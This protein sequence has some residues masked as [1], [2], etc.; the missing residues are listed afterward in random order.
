MQGWGPPTI[1]TALGTP[2]LLQ[3]GEGSLLWLVG[4]SFF[5]APANSSQGSFFLCRNTETGHKCQDTE[6][7]APGGTGRLCSLQNGVPFL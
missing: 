5:T 1:S 4:A 3:E 6:S 2:L 7:G